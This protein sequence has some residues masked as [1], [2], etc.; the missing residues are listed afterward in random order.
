MPMI[1]RQSA[2]CRSVQTKWTKD[3]EIR[4]ELDRQLHFMLRVPLVIIRDAMPPLRVNI[5][6]F[7]KM[8]SIKRPCD[9][10]CEQFISA[11]GRTCDGKHL[12][13]ISQPIHVVDALLS[14]RALSTAQMK[15]IS[16]VCRE[17]HLCFDPLFLERCVKPSMLATFRSSPKHA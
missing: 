13:V 12:D 16:T 8:R 5:P 7:H 10:L 15:F 1:N 11:S 14:N 4:Q 6:R 2:W 9:G 3:Y 17:R